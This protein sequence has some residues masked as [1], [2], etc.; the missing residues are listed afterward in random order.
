METFQVQRVLRDHRGH[1]VFLTTS[2][3]RPERLRNSP[4]VTQKWG[5][6]SGTEDGGLQAGYMPDL[7]SPL[8]LGPRAG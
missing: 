7:V 1:L 6:P 8:F 5:H 2:K 3:G 4:G